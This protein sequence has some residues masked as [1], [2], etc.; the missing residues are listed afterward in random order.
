M[1]KKQWGIVVAALLISL[2]AL[3]KDKN[4]ETTGGKI[5]KLEAKSSAFTDG[6]MIPAKYTCDGPDISPPLEVKGIPDG[7]KTLA[8]ISDD[9]DAPRG[10]WVHWVL[11]DWPAHESVFAEGLPKTAELPNGA[12]QGTNDF[13]RFGYG[14]P[15]PPSGV[16]RYYFKV[17]A[18]DC[19]LDKPAGLTKQ[20]LLAAME[21]H[22]LAEG[23]L[24]GKYSRSR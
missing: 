5:M 7:A 4:V 22:V 14:G 8:L 9:P 21:G 15:C 12:R 24:M 23:Q 11:Y 10:T 18:L 3:A 20:Q 16:H 2:S 6:G 19:K 13:R 1:K 17:Y